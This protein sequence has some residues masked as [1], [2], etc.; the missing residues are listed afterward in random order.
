MLL[1]ALTFE[2]SG[3]R[4]EG[5]WPAQRMMTLAGARA[6][7]LAG[8]CP[9]ERRVRP[10]SPPGSGREARLNKLRLGSLVAVRLGQRTCKRYEC[11]KGQERSCARGEEAKERGAPLRSRELKK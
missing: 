11:P 10:H 7:C 6:K 2:L 3:R 5:A 9:L 4:R 1:S 8:G